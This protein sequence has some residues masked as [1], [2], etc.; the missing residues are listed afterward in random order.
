MKSEE[1]EKEEQRKERADVG[2]EMWVWV[3]DLEGGDRRVWTGEERASV[4]EVVVAG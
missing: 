4:W 2:K 3:Q 1:W